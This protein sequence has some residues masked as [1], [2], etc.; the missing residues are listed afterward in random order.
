MFK[1]FS[2][3]RPRRRTKLKRPGSFHPIL[4]SGRLLLFI[5]GSSACRLCRLHR[6][7]SGTAKSRSAKLRS[8]TGPGCTMPTLLTSRVI[9]PRP[10]ASD[11]AVAVARDRTGQPDAAAVAV[12]PD[13]LLA[14]GLA[15]LGRGA[16]DAGGRAGDEDPFLAVHRDDLV[17]VFRRS[18][19]ASPA[20]RPR[21]EG[22]AAAR[23]GGNATDP[24]LA[25]MPPVASGARAR[26]GGFR[27]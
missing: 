8:S 16:A 19:S 4:S 23:S 5:P 11:R 17:L 14:F 21:R 27:S 26:R 1:A 20:S 25:T 7:F 10:R 15:A 22:E 12:Y 6:R 13:D 3:R 18:R 2:S 24:A 9:R